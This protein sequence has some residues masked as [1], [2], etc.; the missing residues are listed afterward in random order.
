MK[1]LNY[2]LL[3]FASSVSAAEPEFSCSES[4]ELNPNQRFSHEIISSDIGD[5]K[6]VNDKTT[7]LQWAFCLAGQSLSSDQSSCESE[8]T[9]PVDVES[10]KNNGFNL[11]QVAMSAL[12]KENHRINTDGGDWRLPSTKELLS[13]YNQTCIPALYSTFSYNPNLTETEIEDLTTACTGCS[14]QDDLYY[15]RERAKA[16]QR[17]SL[18]SDTTRADDKAVQTYHVVHFSASDS[19]IAT[20][21]T[22]AVTKPL[23][24]PMRLVRKIPE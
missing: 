1:Y 4:S 10:A 22:F 18:L 24:A 14:E 19:P 2:L 9:F 15:D 16:Y 6:V 21:G 13:I 12:T 3:F 8:P 17:Y 11:R 20:S 23:G 7:G 5:Y